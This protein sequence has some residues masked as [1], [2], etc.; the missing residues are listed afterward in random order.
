ME[1]A[2][3]GE[4]RILERT[5]LPR[6]FEALAGD[7]YRI[8]G[9][10]VRDGAIVYDTLRSADDLPI[11]WTDRQEAGKYRLE[12]RADAAVF[13]FAVGPHSWKKYLS[14]ARERLWVARRTGDGFTV[15]P[16][17]I[18][19]RPVAF[20]G[21]RGCEVAAVQIS[22]RV[23]R[24]P[25][26]DPGFA[27]RQRVSLK[28]GVQCSSPAGTC[29]CVSM[30]TG[31]GISAGVDVVM[32][33]IV[34]PKRHHFVVTAR[35]PAGARLLAALP[36]RPA[37]PRE[38]TDVES[39][40]ERSA[41][42]MGRQFEPTGV[43]ETLLSNPEHPRWQI[44]A[45]RCLSCGNCTMVCPTCFCTTTEEV[46]SLDGT[47]SERWRRWDSCFNLAFS[48]L[49]S[50]SVRAS[51][52]SRYRQWLTHK[53]STWHDQFGTS[54]CVGCGR[55]ITWCPVGIDLTEEVAAIRGSPPP[56]G[57]K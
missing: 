30:G 10:T 14:P 52:M 28:I 49:H 42:K 32:T 50:G 1:P 20:L 21:M 57:T 38:I 51:P 40:M 41:S 19:D 18:D 15:T 11:G 48:Q 25:S 23:F 13:G 24:G 56:G 12:R 27:A 33:E 47:E 31:P 22:S 44:V 45:Q 39:Q 43:R 29:F 5:D 2:E 7:G 36:T 16:E 46:P 3:P 34:D 54:G 9:P 8:L 26:A 17:P 35:T 55:C 53:L 6:L 4:P 37:E